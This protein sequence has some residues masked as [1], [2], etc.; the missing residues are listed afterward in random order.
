MCGLDFTNKEGINMQNGADLE[1][2][3][4]GLVFI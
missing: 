2:I 3:A 1:C 4:S